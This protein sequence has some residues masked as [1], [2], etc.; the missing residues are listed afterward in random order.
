MLMVRELI[1]RLDLEWES[2][3]LSDVELGLR[4]CMKARCLGLSSLERTMAKQRSRVWQLSEGDANTAYFHLIA[5]K[6]KHRGFIPS[7]SVA[8][9]VVADHAEM[10]NALCEHFTG[11]FGTASPRA[12]TINLQAVGI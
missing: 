12:S 10:E 8:G 1:H 4:K 3:Q 9:H 11:V 2:R 6:K 7:F 5:R